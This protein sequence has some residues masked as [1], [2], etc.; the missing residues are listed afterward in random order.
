M[1]TQNRFNRYEID[2]QIKQLLY[3]KGSYEL[4]KRKDI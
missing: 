3:E 4:S 1:S 2:F